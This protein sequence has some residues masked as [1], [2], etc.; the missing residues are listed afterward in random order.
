MRVL[1]IETDGS[2]AAQI[3]DM[4]E[5]AVPRWMSHRTATSASRTF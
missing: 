5:R 1:V 2:L 3:R 4:L